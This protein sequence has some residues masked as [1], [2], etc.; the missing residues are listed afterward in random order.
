MKTKHIVY[1]VISIVTVLVFG[2]FFARYHLGLGNPPL[3]VMHPTIEYMFK[4]NQD[5]ERFGNRIL[6]NEFG[7]RA[8]QF[9]RYKKNDELR[10]LVFG[11]SVVS[12]GNLTDHDDLA[13]SLIGLN[14]R[15]AGYKEVVVGNISAG[16][17]GPGNWLAYVNEYGFFD[18]DIIVLVISSHD[19]M[20]NPKFQ[21]LNINTHPTESPISAFVEGVT[22][23][24][25]RYLPQFLSDFL[26]ENAGVDT[27]ENAGKAA[28]IGLADL[29]IFLEL[30]KVGSQR[31]LV[32]QHWEKKELE[33]HSARLGNERIREVCKRIGISSVSLEPYFR[34]SIE[35][36]ANPYRDKIHLNEVGQQ[37]IA[38][39]IITNLADITHP[40]SVGR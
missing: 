5:V 20:D 32:L 35:G 4:P 36:G 11:D 14:L 23:Y 31:V 9:S 24:L 7:M 19:Y 39:V 22:R 15:G 38:K 16:S 25:P 8:T 6:I 2:E 17:W 34:R 26:T 28:E 29:K 37:L 18:A 3:S 21:Q 33:D 30:A 13:T 10:L 27:E 40:H 1:G 12:G